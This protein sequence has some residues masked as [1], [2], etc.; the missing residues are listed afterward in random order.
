MWRHTFH[1]RFKFTI[2]CTIN[3]SIGSTF[4]EFST[5]PDSCCPC[6]SLT[7]LSPC[8]FH[9]CFITKNSFPDCF[10]TFPD[11]SSDKSYFYHIVRQISYLY[12]S[13]SYFLHWRY[14]SYLFHA[15]DSILR[16]LELFSDIKAITYQDAIFC[17]IKSSCL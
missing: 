1:N 3:N 14:D 10:C 15:F 13:S 16:C 9:S 8:L 6:G 7:K 2:L 12:S 4:D 11:S 17:H 5:I